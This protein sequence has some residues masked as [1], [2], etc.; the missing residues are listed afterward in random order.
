V[1]A[2]GA[3]YPDGNPG[4]GLTVVR[5]GGA[6][7]ALEWQR[8]SSQPSDAR[9]LT[10]DGH[11]DVYLAGTGGTSASNALAVAKIAGA[12]GDDAWITRQSDAD[13]RWQTAQR[14]VVDGDAVFA[15]GMTNDGSGQAGD[16]DGWVFRVTRLDP[17]TGAILWTYRDGGAYHPGFASGLAVAADG[18]V[19]AAG[20]TGTPATCT[21]AFV[22]SLDRA[23]GALC[24]SDTIDGPLS[25]RYCNASCE[26]GICSDADLDGWTGSASTAPGAS[27][28]LAISSAGR[29]GVPRS[30][31]SSVLSAT[32]PFRRPRYQSRRPAWDSSASTSPR[33]TRSCAS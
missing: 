7:G 9:D 25:T 23:T 17:A 18:S 27:S 10:V 11:G 29:R 30:R 4:Y 24:S 22:V 21:D 14:V 13:G 19:I 12:T 1:I 33:S 16:S 8:V 5:L 31:R 2:A 15:A 28:S 32:D 3:V 26:A 20:F 6:D